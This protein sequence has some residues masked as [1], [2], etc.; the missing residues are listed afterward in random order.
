M[1]KF[2]PDNDSKDPSTISRSG[3]RLNG[4]IFFVVFFILLVLKVLPGTYGNR[5]MGGVVWLLALALF[6]W[7]IFRLYGGPSNWFEPLREWVRNNK[8][9]AF[10][11]LLLV[12]GLF[13]SCLNAFQ[14]IRQYGYTGP[15]PWSQ[16]GKSKGVSI[17]KVYD[18]QLGKH[19]VEFSVPSKKDF[20][21][22]TN[23]KR[24]KGIFSSSSILKFKM[25]VDSPLKIIINVKI[26]RVQRTVDYV[27]AEKDRTV[28]KKRTRS[29]RAAFSRS[30]IYHGLGA[31]LRSG[32]WRT[33][34]L[35][36]ETDFLEEGLPA[37]TGM[38]SV[39]EIWIQGTGRIDDTSLRKAFGFAWTKQQFPLVLFVSALASYIFLFLSYALFRLYPG[40]RNYLWALALLLLVNIIPFWQKFDYN[41]AAFFLKHTVAALVNQA[42]TVSLTGR[43][44]SVLRWI[45]IYCPF[46]AVLAVFFWGRFLVKKSTGFCRYFELLVGIFCIGG[47]I[48]PG[49]RT[50]IV[51]L[52]AGFAA[53]IFY[54]SG[55]RKWWIISLALVAVFVMHIFVLWNPYMGEKV[56]RFLPYVK[57]LRLQEPLKP[58]DFVPDFAGTYSTKEGNRLNRIRQAFTFWRENPWFGIGLGQY[59]IT[60][61]HYWPGNVHNL[62]F[63][64]L[65]EA[66]IFVFAAWLY[67]AGRFVWRRRRSYLMAVVVTIFVVSCFEN[68]FDHSMPWVLTCAWIFSRDEAWTS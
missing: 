63:N 43:L 23:H 53:L 56:G 46:A 11:V 7:G 13:I 28:T 15:G 44:H 2:M 5:M 27:D 22:M 39:A 31:D 37:G 19:V 59:N 16:R 9:T 60:S 3:G 20:M 26:P 34:A 42:G 17:K 48:L 62:F 54:V 51:S 24:K 10:F 65:C 25:K 68:L 30:K 66:G 36:L 38:E 52:F 45:T 12:A 1:K 55:R 21:K 29:G 6:I 18:H 49:S 35:D 61:G 50:G 64:I 57:K 4:N 32:E 41:S 14:D 47:A 40:N 67:F 58:H 8:T 33:I